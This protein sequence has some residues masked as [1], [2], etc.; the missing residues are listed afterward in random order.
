M[1]LWSCRYKDYS[2]KRGFSLD[3]LPFIGAI[4][5]IDNGEN[6]GGVKINL[7]VGLKNMALK[8][9]FELISGK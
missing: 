5:I 2:S 3:P 9:L 6:I 8:K 4:H 1:Y 7:L